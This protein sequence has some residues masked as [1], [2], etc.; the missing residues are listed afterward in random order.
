[1]YTKEQIREAIKELIKSE[2]EIMKKTFE[3]RIL[4][5]PEIKNA[6]K[7]RQNDF[8]KTN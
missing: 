3:K 8:K 4:A 6:V 1:M 5:L 2:V 7:G